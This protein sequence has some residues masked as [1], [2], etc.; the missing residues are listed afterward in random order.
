MSKPLY[1]RRPLETLAITVLFLVWCAKAQPISA[2]NPQPEEKPESIRGVVVN[3]VTHEPV[4]RALVHSGDNR[5]A[6]FTD[7]EGR[8]EFTFPQADSD[9]SRADESGSPDR[10]RHRRQNLQIVLMAKKPGFLEDHMGI[11]NRQ[12]DSAGKEITIPLTPE[13]LVVG[14]VVLAA[15]EPSD[16]IQLEL[17]RR[18]VQEG[19]AHWVLSGSAATKS[20]GEFRFAELAAGNYKLLTR[21]LLDRDPLTFDPRGQLYGYPPIYFPNAIN[22]EAAQ[23]IQ[24]TAGQTFQAG[25]SLVRHAY[26]PVKVAVANVPDN[27]RG[28]NIVVSPQGRR[29]PGFALG[30]NNQTQ[31]IEGLLPDGNYTLEASSFGP[32]AASGWMNLSVKGAAAEGSRMTVVPNGSIKVNVKDEFTSS[33]EANSPTFIV[34]SGP[35]DINAQG[36]RRYLNVRLEPADDFVQRGTAWLRPPS[37]PDD[38]SL[39]IEGVQPGRYWVKVDSTRGFVSAVSS[40]A[41]DLQHH[42][43]I[44][45]PGGSS[46]PIEIIMRDDT[47]EIDGSI[48]GLASSLTGSVPQTADGSSAHLYCIPLPDSSGDFKDIWVQADGKFGPQQMPPGTY[49]VLAF[50]RPQPDLEYRNPEAMKAYD[51]KGQ[52]VRLIAGQKEHL[53][54]QLVSS[55]E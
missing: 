7:S 51:A 53:H 25:I 12:T 40:G 50:D 10:F 34:H 21:E 46:A 5:Y 15:S 22:F 30:Y 38:E 44:V 52:L 45:G 55:T 18:Q 42:P 9:K 49:R 16:T 36:P 37:G 28:F 39:V 11:Q 35:P 47:A 43:L 27:V 13:A 20:N 1:P 32:N 2:Q 31:M 4:G 26:Y 3:S 14:R 19:R 8:F 33:E 17:Y 6:M 23:T 24:L 54:L 41:T 48:E 29:G